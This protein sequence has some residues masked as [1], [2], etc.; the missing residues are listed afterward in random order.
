MMPQSAYIKARR[1]AGYTVF[2]FACE[3]KV[4][5]KFISNGNGISMARLQQIGNLFINKCIL[6]S[7]AKVL[8]FQ[9]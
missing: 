1:Q 4:T 9:W 8:G 7:D 2:Q 3:D 6:C 5:A